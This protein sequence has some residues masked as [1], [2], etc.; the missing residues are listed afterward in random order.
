MVFKGKEKEVI[1]TEVDA[2]KRLVTFISIGKEKEDLTNFLP[3]S[4]PNL[5][6]EK[7]NEIVENIEM[8]NSA[9]KSDNVELKIYGWIGT[10]KTTKG[11]KKRNK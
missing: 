1:P 3:K 8:D 5:Q 2:V 7:I 10:Y 4:E 11:M 6:I 9:G